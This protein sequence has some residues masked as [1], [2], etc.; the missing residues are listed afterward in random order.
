MGDFNPLKFN[1]RI[2]RFQYLVYFLIWDAFLFVVVLV[3]ATLVAR[4]A[5]GGLS[6]DALAGFDVFGGVIGLVLLAS[7]GGRRMHDMDRSAWWIL[8]V[9]VPIVDVVLAL[10]LL[11]APGSKGPNRYGA[12]KKRAA[13]L[14]G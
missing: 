8:L 6:H 12:R 10:A 7:Y 3:A 11:L 2:G 1:G 9:F 5:P 4:N 13:T 14:D